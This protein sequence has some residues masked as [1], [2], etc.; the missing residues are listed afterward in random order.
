MNKAAND[1][2]AHANAKRALKR[3]K[4]LIDAER[5]SERAASAMRSRQ[6]STCAALEALKAHERAIDRAIDR[7]KATSIEAMRKSERVVKIMRVY[8]HTRE[9]GNGSMV[10]RVMGRR[11]GRR[12]DRA[13]GGSFEY[14]CDGER[15]SSVIR[16]VEIAIDGKVVGA[17]VRGRND[18]GKDGFEVRGTSATG[19][20]GASGEATVK[21]WLNHE[22]ERFVVDGKLAKMIGCLDCT[23]ARFITELWGYCVANQLTGDG[24]PCE[25]TVDDDLLEV[26]AD[27]F[28]VPDDRKVNFRVLCEFMCANK[29]APFPPIE[30]KY[31]IGSSG[32]TPVKPECYDIEVDVVKPTPGLGSWFEAQKL[33]KS[34][35]ACENRIKSAMNVLETHV[36]HRNYL[37]RFAESPIDF[38]NACV[39][40]QA[41]GVYAP[42]SAQPGLEPARWSERAADMYREPWV[43]EAVLRY[44]DDSSAPAVGE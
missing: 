26:L 21:L 9:D 34:I 7:A 42:S 2:L 19:R 4:Q 33:Q 20:G 36:Q 41:Q 17:W 10:T 15:F 5:A 1:A 11:V 38:I 13:R 30:I 40:Q 35:D 24:D 28:P 27:G 39:L 18:S 44:L 25:V 3:K 32:A 8:A 12:E 31:K 43:D 29:L 6:A 22:P 37:L 14:D 16:A 23:R